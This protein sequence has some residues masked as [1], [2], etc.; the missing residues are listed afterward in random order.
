MLSDA[1][2]PGKHP[3]GFI[4]KKETKPVEHIQKLIESFQSQAKEMI[5]TSH[6]PLNLSEPNSAFCFLLHRG[7][8]NLF[9]PKR[10]LVLNTEHAPFVFGFS[11]LCSS[12]PS[13]ALI[14][15][16]DA[17]FSVL[18][19][20]NACDIVAKKQLWQSLSYLLMYISSRVYDHSTRLSQMNSYE[21]VRNILMELCEESEELRAE[22]SV[23]HYIQSRCYL[24]RSGIM[25]ILSE[26]RAGNY[27]TIQ[28]GTL[29]DVHTLPKKF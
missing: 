7:H 6:H 16:S 22:T 17:A 12:A 8:V 18:P 27:I 13:M 2:Y 24:S 3:P 29:V 26:L 4:N 23:L 25:R 28:D 20:A 19:L 5:I 9:N 10:N 11:K 14:P 1:L 15:S 21:T